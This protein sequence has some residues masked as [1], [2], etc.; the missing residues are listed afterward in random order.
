MTK[1]NHIPYPTDEEIES[2]IDFI[3]KRGLPEQKSFFSQLQTLQSQLGWFNLL[4]NRNEWIFTFIAVSIIL[5][6]V[7]LTLSNE[8]AVTPTYFALLFMLSPFI[9]AS[10]SLYSFYDK[11]E[12]HTYELEMTTKYTMF[13]VIGIRMLLFSSFAIL[14]NTSFSV[15]LSFML[16]IEFF[17][18]WLLSLTGLFV[19]ATGLLTIMKSGQVARKIIAYVMGWIFTNSLLIIFANTYYIQLL[20]QLPIV[21]YTILI[22]LLIGLFFSAFKQMYLRKQ[23]GIWLC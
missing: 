16:E 5:L 11:K 3:V 12:N 2:Q 23:E 15:W 7:W 1:Y 13:Q 19:F 22:I 21:V 18:L 4:P 8:A 14:C 17:R 10:L 20:I 6:F 9:F